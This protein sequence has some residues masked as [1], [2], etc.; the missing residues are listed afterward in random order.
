[1]TDAHQAFRQD[2]HQ[3]P[4]NKLG[5]GELHDTGLVFSVIFIT[6]RYLVFIHIDKALITDRNTMTVASQ[7]SDNTIRV[8]EI[9]LET[10][11]SGLSLY[12]K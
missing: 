2:M 9:R 11:G 7:V 4:S 12:A 6:E 3:E 1:M 8:I 5:A 10:T